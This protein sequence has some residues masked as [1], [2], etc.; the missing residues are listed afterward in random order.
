M[1]FYTKDF[2]KV[3]PEL[4]KIKDVDTL[5]NITNNGDYTYAHLVVKYML[6]NIPH[7]QILDYV[8]K[9]KPFRKEC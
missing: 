2:Y 8:K 1:R 7:K 9:R 4:D 6:K 5:E 3:I